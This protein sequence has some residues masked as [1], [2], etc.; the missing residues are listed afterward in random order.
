MIYI[1]LPFFQNKIA[2]E[3]IIFKDFE[4][5]MITKFLSFN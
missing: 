1:F 4:L 2:C 3:C 5:T